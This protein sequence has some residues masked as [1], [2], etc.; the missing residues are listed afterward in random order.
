MRNHFGRSGEV[1]GQRRGPH[2]WDLGAPGGCNSGHLGVVRRHDDSIEQPR[3]PRR[4]DRPG[5]HRL[6]AKIAD[7]LSRYAFA[8][9]ARGND[10]NGAAWRRAIHE[11]RVFNSIRIE[12]LYRSLCSCNQAQNGLAAGRRRHCGASQERP[13]VIIYMGRRLAHPSCLVVLNDEIAAHRSRIRGRGVRPNPHL[14]V[15]VRDSGGQ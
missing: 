10:G 5:D 3:S 4:I 1:V 13:S 6:A 7:I 9:A 14:I 12:M 15:G 8:A 2:E 11:R